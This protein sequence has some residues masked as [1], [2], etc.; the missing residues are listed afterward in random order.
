MFRS[1]IFCF[2]IWVLTAL[3]AGISGG[4]FCLFFF[5]GN[6]GWGESF[7]L[8][9]VGTLFCSAPAMSIFWLIALSNRN[10]PLLFRT[11]LQRILVLSA[12]SCILL[13]FLPLDEPGTHRLG[14]SICVVLS[15]LSSVMLHHQT[16]L[17]FSNR[18]I[19]SHV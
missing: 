5:A 18:K 2:T 16:I 7:M 11:L 15:G 8:V 9:F 19:N 14:L 12:A 13:F 17:S 6:P 10:S 4:S 1:I 3:L